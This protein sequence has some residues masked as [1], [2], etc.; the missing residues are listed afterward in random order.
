ME[1]KIQMHESPH[2]SKSECWRCLLPMLYIYWALSVSLSFSFYF[3]IYLCFNCDMVVLIATT[4]TNQNFIDEAEKRE[5]AKEILLFVVIMGL[6]VNAT[7]FVWMLSLHLLQTCLIL[8]SIEYTNWHT[9]THTQFGAIEMCWIVHAMSVF[10]MNLYIF[11]LKLQIWFELPAHIFINARN[12]VDK[13]RA[14]SRKYFN[15]I[16][17]GSHEIA[18]MYVYKS[19][20]QSSAIWKLSDIQVDGLAL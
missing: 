12:P 2:V 8:Q 7:S 1:Q 13:H 4:T 10:T 5:S 18:K 19:V 6:N 16:W 11:P 14:H 15:A 9:H 20:D 3:G 17:I